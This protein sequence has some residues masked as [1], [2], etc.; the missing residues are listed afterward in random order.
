MARGA[1][2]ELTGVDVG[3]A[4]DHAVATAEAIGVGA[5]ARVRIADNVAGVGPAAVWVRKSLGIEA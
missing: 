2:S 4:R 3:S 5:I 1:G